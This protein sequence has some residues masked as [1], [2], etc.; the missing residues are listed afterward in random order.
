MSERFV[1]DQNISRFRAL[2]ETETDGEKRELLHALLIR[3][4]DRIGS[5][6]ERLEHLNAFIGRLAVLT[7]RQ[8]RAIAD[9]VSDGRDERLARLM[10]VQLNR[11]HA[12]FSHRRQVLGRDLTASLGP[13]PGQIEGVVTLPVQPGG[14]GGNRT[15]SAKGQRILKR[16]ERSS[17]TI[18]NGHAG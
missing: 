4:E 12:L 5:L 16:P 11:T 10:L 8:K 13:A 2:L 17:W 14:D 7:A 6:V 3:E 9:L 1:R 18:W 15:V